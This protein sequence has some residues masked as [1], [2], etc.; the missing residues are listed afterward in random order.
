MSALVQVERKDRWALCTLSQPEKRNPLS[1]AMR[2]Q[3]IAELETLR[4]DDA[5]RAVVI[6]GSGSAFC[7]GLDLQ[8]LADQAN[9]SEPEHLADSLSIHHFFEYI[10]AYPK[11]TMAAVNGPAVAGGCGLALLCDVTIAAEDA[12]FCFSEV[13]IGFIPALVG[14]YLQRMIGAKAASEMLLTARKVPAAEG[15]NRGMVSRVVSGADLLAT[16]GE[17]AA[18]V[19]QNSPMAVQ[20]SKSLLHKAMHLPLE[21]AL[22]LAVEVNAQARSSPQCKEGVKAFLEK[23][24][25][26]WSL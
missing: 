21:K 15:L 25:P 14:V 2:D 10:A 9:L 19:A 20:V 17:L 1:R 11:P 8:G 26:N 24:P 13:K 16:A 22:E 23:R 3:V 5:V 12:W 7:S 4:Q 6:T 18:Q